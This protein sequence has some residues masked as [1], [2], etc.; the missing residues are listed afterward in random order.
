MLYH[1][2]PK[3]VMQNF[4]LTIENKIDDTTYNGLVRNYFDKTKPF[5][6][7]GRNLDKIETVR[8]VSI[9]QNGVDVDAAR[10]PM[11]KVIITFDKPIELQKSDIIRI[12]Q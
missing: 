1:E 3:T 11:T 9:N 7:L 2:I 12:K 10:S 8:I 4:V 6:V 5:E